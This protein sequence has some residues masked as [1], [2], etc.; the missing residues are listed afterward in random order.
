MRI[1]SMTCPN[2]GATLQIDADKK[3]LTCS[4]CGNNLVIDD[5]VQHIQYDNA[6]E[7]GY[8]FEKGRLRAQEEASQNTMSNTLQFAQQAPVKKRKT[9]LWILGWIIIF[10]V[11]LTILLLRKKQMKPILKYGII[12]AAWILYLI[13]GFSG[14]KDKNDSKS[15]SAAVSISSGSNTV[16]TAGSMD[17]VELIDNRGEKLTDSSANYIDEFISSI[18]SAEDISL[19][20][21]EDFVPSDSSNGHYRTEFRLNAYKDAYGKS[22]KFGDTTVDIILSSDGTIQRIY[23]DGASYEQCEVMIRRASSLLDPSVT[24][25]EIQ[26]AID[27]FA[28]RKEANGYYYAKLGLVILG[29]GN[30]HF[31]FM[32]KLS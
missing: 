28:E 32:L 15:T 8:Q 9:W 2:C 27:N 11:P 7:T 18:N 20:Y 21:V 25:S 29:R 16:E 19:E 26:E 3:Q 31:H 5:E 13:I 23:M 4:Y 10:P 1:V 24:D 14:S 22:Y 12:V 6:E 17:S 30:E